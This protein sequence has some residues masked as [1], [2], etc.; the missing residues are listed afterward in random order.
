MYPGV[1]N[2][3]IP[4]PLPFVDGRLYSYGLEVMKEPIELHLSRELIRREC[5]GKW[6]TRLVAPNGD[7]V[8]PI[9]VCS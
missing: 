5:G 1:S 7:V 6:K 9:T 3:V 4:Y 2:H 8:A